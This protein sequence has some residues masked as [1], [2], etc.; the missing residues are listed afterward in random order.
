MS[1]KGSDGGKQ[2]GARRLGRGL[3]SLIGPAPVRVDVPPEPPILDSERQ[4]GD[5]TF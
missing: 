1:Q 5:I 2:G 4:Y 3:S